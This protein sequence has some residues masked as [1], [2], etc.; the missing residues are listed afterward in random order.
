MAKDRFKT[1]ASYDTTFKYGEY[2]TP[3]HST[4]RTITEKQIKILGE[5]YKKPN[6]SDWDKDFIKS[7]LKFNTLSKKQRDIL[8]TI[9]IKY[10]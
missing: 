10:I 1:R 3:I 5:L 4:K 8:N 6:I 7:V 2:I 9:Y